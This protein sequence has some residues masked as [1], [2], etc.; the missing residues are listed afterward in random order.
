MIGVKL[1]AL[2]ARNYFKEVKGYEAML[3]TSANKVSMKSVFTSKYNVGPNFISTL[4]PSLI[5]AVNEIKAHI[6]YGIYKKKNSDDYFILVEKED[7]VF[8]SSIRES[9]DGSLLYVV[10]ESGSV[11]S[12]SKKNGYAREI[13]IPMLL[14]DLEVKKEEEVLECVKNIKGDFSDMSRAYIFVLCDNYYR[15]FEAMNPNAQVNDNMWA[16]I[17]DKSIISPELPS[18]LDFF[19][20]TS[21]GVVVKREEEIRK[22]SGNIGIPFSSDETEEEKSVECLYNKYKIGEQPLDMSNIEHYKPSPQLLNILEMSDCGMRTFMLRGEAGCGKTT[23]ADVLARIKGVKRYVFT[24]SEK[25]DETS[26]ISTFIPTK[27]GF[28]QVN[29]PL[30]DACLEPSVCEIQEPACISKQAVLVA[31]NNLLDDNGTIRLIDGSCITIN[32]D[33]IFVFTTN[34]DYIGCR[35]MNESVI[36]RMDEVIDYPSLTVERYVERAVSKFGKLNNKTLYNMA[37]T[38]VGIQQYMKE[39]G[40]TGG[41]C[42]QREFFNWIKAAVKTRDVKRA[43]EYTVIGKTSKDE[44]IRSEIREI[45]V[46]TRISDSMAIQ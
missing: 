16:F 9:K 41:V 43:C 4:I 45:C 10:E 25:T 33:T 6:E 26:L 46:N 14:F 12:I 38:I 44:S 8:M 39:E 21:D 23:D 11:I 29:S 5:D 15:R 13:F 3:D 36:S 31:L 7:T 40:I 37:R 20:V 32:P 34:V 2:F 27:D 1:P 17:D 22:I 42:G 28:R 35:D 24:C 19:A 30:I 18:P